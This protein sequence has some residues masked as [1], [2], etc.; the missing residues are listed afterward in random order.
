MCGEAH[1][2]IP[3]WKLF[4]PFC[5]T[6][7]PPKSEVIFILMGDLK[8]LPFLCGEVQLIDPHK[9]IWAQRLRNVSFAQIKRLRRTC[10]A[11][12]RGMLGAA[13]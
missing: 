3:A 13:A 1:L 8:S 6:K 10:L 9:G 5:C 7:L 11:K 4:V 2:K 12:L